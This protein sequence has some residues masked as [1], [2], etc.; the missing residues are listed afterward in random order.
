VI[1]AGVLSAAIVGSVA[2]I[3]VRGGSPAP[4]VPKPPPVSTATVV[5]TT[6]ADSVL[7][8]GTLGYAATDP[9]INGLTGTYTQL[10]SVGT[11]VSAGQV[12]Y[13]V[14]NL[15]VVL[16][17]GGT[18]AW[19]LF[20]AGMT[21]GPDVAELQSSLIGLGDASGLF[22]TASDHFDWRTVDAIERW[23]RA[24]GQ[25][26]TGQIPLGQVVFLPTAV[27]VGAQS[28]EIGHAA[29]VGDLPYQVTT[30][31]R[32]VTV[33]LDPANAP[34][35]SVGEPATITF[36]SNSTTPGTITA[37]GPI[38]PSLSS[39]STSSQGGSSSAATPSEQLTVT[40][41]NP[42][43]TGTAIGVAV[44][45]SLT[46]EQAANVL[47]APISA[48]LALSGGDYGVEIV[49]PSGAHRLVGVTTGLYSNTLVEI[50]GSGIMAGT[51]VVVAQ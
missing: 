31:A 19:R 51:K 39:S 42:S 2:T 6:L 28:V 20:A 37:I 15:P 27:L 3:A 29:A 4:A 47:A 41:S 8:A 48:L 12:L 23:Q 24:E 30:T 43:V 14:D 44:Q 5:R 50:R 35:V 1:I 25:P 36:P 18:P 9:L 38:P 34:T 33:P 11:V 22:S 21:D 26:A 45:V 16:M 7:M 40:P 46:T 49:E 10:P 32:T 17:T 13:R